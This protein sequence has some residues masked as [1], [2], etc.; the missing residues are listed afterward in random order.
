MLS[1]KLYVGYI[2]ARYYIFILHVVIQ[3]I[4]INNI[5]LQGPNFAWHIDQYDKLCAFGFKI[6]GCIDGYVFML[7]YIYCSVNCLIILLACAVHAL[8]LSS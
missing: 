2:Q 3:C 1:I 8:C 7:T 5:V 4:I 6:H